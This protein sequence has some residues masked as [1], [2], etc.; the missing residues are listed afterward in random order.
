LSFLEPR[1][2]EERVGK[3]GSVEDRIVEC[4]RYLRTPQSAVAQVGEL[5]VDLVKDSVRQ[6]D[7]Y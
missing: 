5:Q 2:P 1:V 3:V 4:R 7:T 6:V